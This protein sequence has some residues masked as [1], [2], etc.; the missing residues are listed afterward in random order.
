MTATFARIQQNADMEWKF[1]RAGPTK[2]Q[3]YVQ[4]AKANSAGCSKDTAN[5]FMFLLK[6]RFFP[7]ANKLNSI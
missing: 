6:Y 2:T 1:I 7:A 4:C 3:T 5:T